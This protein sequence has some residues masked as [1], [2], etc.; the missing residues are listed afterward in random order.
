MSGILRKQII[1]NCPES[2]EEELNTFI[3]KVEDRI[4]RIKD[5]MNITHIGQLSDIEEAYDK[6]SELA[7]D[8]Y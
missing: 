7:N 5:I 2:F 4:N 1:D 8:L 3:N 6:L